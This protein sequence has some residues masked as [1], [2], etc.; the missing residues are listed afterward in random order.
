VADI[1]L[2]EGNAGTTPATFEFNLNTTS[3][4]PVVLFWQTEDDTAT[5]GTACVAGID[6]LVDQGTLS[7]PPG[8]QQGSVTILVCGDTVIEPTERFR[9]RFTGIQGGV[10]ARPAACEASIELARLAGAGDAAVICSIMRDDGEMARIDDIGQLLHEYRLTVA[11]I[12]E[13]MR[14]LERERI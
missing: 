4:D 13:L 14:R 2:F 5:G 9:L 1:T 11:D 8:Q 7:F 10:L 6:Y 3:A 12:T